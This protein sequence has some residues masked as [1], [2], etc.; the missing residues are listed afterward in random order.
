VKWGMKRKTKLAMDHSLPRYACVIKANQSLLPCTQQG[1]LS[2]MSKTVPVRVLRSE[3]SQVI[4]QVADLRE[5]VIVTRR[6][7]PAAVLV[8]V[9]EYEA[10]EETAEILSDPDTLAAI[11]EGRQEAERGETVTLAE[12][13]RELDCQRR[14]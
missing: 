6:G 3:L 8:P 7:R 5:H 10:L 14:S 9:G 2:K 11:D 12:L 4:D 1:T 13:R